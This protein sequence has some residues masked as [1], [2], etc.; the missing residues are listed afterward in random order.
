MEDIQFQKFLLETAVCSMACDG[1]IDAREV[2]ELQEIIKYTQYF[3]DINISEYLVTFFQE[4]K[5]ESHVLLERYFKNIENANLSY[6]QELLVLEIIL[7]IIYADERFDEN[8]IRFLK[9]LRSKLK[10]H[11]EII[12]H[13]FGDTPLYTANQLTACSEDKIIPDTGGGVAK[14]DLVAADL[15]SIQGILDALQEKELVLKFNGD[16]ADKD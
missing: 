7:R 1:D 5:S 14:V 8:E 11:N 13:R 4:I 16:G 9:L 3:K 12:Y 6:V 10:V 15:S 2:V